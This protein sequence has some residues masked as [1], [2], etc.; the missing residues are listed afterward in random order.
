MSRSSRSGRTPRAGARPRRA[1]C[2]GDGRP[3]IG[4]RARSGPDRRRPAVLRTGSGHRRSAG[5]RP[6]AARPSVTAASRPVPGHRCDGASRERAEEALELG[7]RLLGLVGRGQRRRA[8]RSIAPSCRSSACAASTLRIA[9]MSSGASSLRRTRRTA[10]SGAAVPLT[11]CSAAALTVHSACFCRAAGAGPARTNRAM[12]ARQAARP[13]AWPRRAR[14]D[15]A[16]MP[17]R[18][19]MNRNPSRPGPR[20][21]P[22]RRPRSAPRPAGYGAAAGYSSDRGT[23]PRTP[24]WNSAARTRPHIATAAA[25]RRAQGPRATQALPGRRFRA[26]RRASRAAPPGR[27]GGARPAAGHQ[28]P[29][30]H[31]ATHRKIAPRRMLCQRMPRHANPTSTSCSTS[32]AESAPSPVAPGAAVRPSTRSNF[33]KSSA[34]GRPVVPS[35]EPSR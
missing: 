34:T 16:R 26:G 1:R 33:V 20:P 9:G 8:R 4:G 30:G 2:S 6:T 25:G 3:R 17:W 18:F 24:T 7:Q 29:P 11:T 5:P 19:D 31:S 12:G 14:S 15:R 13:S 21:A 27:A 32:E 28:P 35:R 10:R 22:G 23:R